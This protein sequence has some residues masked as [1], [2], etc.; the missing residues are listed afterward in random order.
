MRMLIVLILTALLTACGD[1][2]QQA[3]TETPT[4]LVVAAK[5]VSGKSI[6]GVELLIEG[7]GTETVTFPPYCYGEAVYDKS[8]S[9]WHVVSISSQDLT[10]K[11]CITFSTPGARY[12]IIQVVTEDK[13]NGI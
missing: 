12:E 13:I 5:P 11:T 9:R 8:I 4:A 6:Y 7:D 2:A 10:G 3:A 1:S